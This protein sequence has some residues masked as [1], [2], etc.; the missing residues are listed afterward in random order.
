MFADFGR[1]V[2]GV[3]PA[4]LSTDEFKKV[5][6][7]LYKVCPDCARASWSKVWESPMNCHSMVF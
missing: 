2:L 3:D 5:E 6:E 7:L 1:E 4:N